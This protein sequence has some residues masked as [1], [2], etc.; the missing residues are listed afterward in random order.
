MKLR[1]VC[2]SEVQKIRVPSIDRKQLFILL[3]PENY[4]DRRPV[5]NIT[6]LFGIRNTVRFRDGPAAVISLFVVG[7]NK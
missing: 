2:R 7:V 1:F 5:A 6:V 3:T 4:Y